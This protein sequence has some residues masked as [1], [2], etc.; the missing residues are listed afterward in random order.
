MQGAP[1]QVRPLNIGVFG[2]PGAGKSFGV[3]SIALDLKP[4][5]TEAGLSIAE[6][7]FNLTNFTTP[8]D[9]NVELRKLAENRKDSILPLVFW[10][11]FDRQ[12]NGRDLGWL[13]SFLVPTFLRA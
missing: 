2:A 4:Q 7:P 10:D 6:Y 5:L 9:L 3:K 13:E 12:L 11:E 8:S 1:E